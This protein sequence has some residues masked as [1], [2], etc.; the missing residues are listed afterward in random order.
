AK[1]AEPVLYRATA[2]DSKE[3]V[4]TRSV[5]CPVCNPTRCGSVHLQACPPSLVHCGNFG[6]DE[7]RFRLPYQPDR[8]H[9]ENLS[10]LNRYPRSC[11]VEVDLFASVS[12]SRNLR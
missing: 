11:G 1:L 4:N 5:L 7:Q 9:S 8:Q 2:G 6:K 12:A 10:V 3:P